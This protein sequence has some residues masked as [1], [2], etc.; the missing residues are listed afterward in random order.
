MRVTFNM[1]YRNA[2]RDIQRTAEALQE[3][4]QQV[5]SGRRVRV[6]SDDPAAV[7]DIIAERSAMRAIDSFQRTTDSAQAR[8]SVADSVLSDV[9]SQLTSA[10]VSTAA[11]QVSFSTPAQ[12][13]ALAQELEQLRNG[14]LS[15][16]NSSYRGTYLFSGTNS[17]VAP[18]SEAGGVVQPYQGNGQRQLLDVGESTTVEVTYDGSAIFG[19][20]FS[21]L[22]QL[23]AA[24]RAGN[25]SG[26]GFNMQE[27]MARLNEAFERL[28]AAQSRV[29]NS[30]KSV[31]G[32]NTR[33]SD[34]KRA[35][36][37]RRSTLEDADLVEAI[38]KMQ[39][40]DSAQKAAIAA[41]GTAS[42]LSLMDYLS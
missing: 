11:A 22:D 8:L 33:L 12:R 6:A 29:G 14:I 25:I 4:Q 36:D 10:Q 9:I 42:R 17:T 20:L 5:S 32:Q 16:A 30:L 31:E 26:A 39:Q 38:T 27:G 3:A 40:A 41:V 28:T 2:V 18:Y 21:D 1:T 34:L 15:A 24:V 23:I 19:D 35:A 7:G 13:E 37:T